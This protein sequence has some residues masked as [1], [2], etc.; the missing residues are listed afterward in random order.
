MMEKREKR[1]KIILFLFFVPF[2][3]WILFQ[4]LAPILLPSG[5]IS[6]LSGS[7][8]I[9]ENKQSI[10]SLNFPWNIIYQSGDALCHQ[11]SERSFFIN[12]NQMPYCARCT[13]IW[14]GITIGIGFMIFF[15]MEINEKFLISIL[16]GLIPIGIDGIGQLFGLW[17]SNNLVRLIT[18]LLA[19][20]ITGIAIGTIIDE[21]RDI[22]KSKKLKF[23]QKI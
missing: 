7:T 21:L 5:T 12:E 23:N 4:L 2:L 20:I 11:K 22:I 14:L 10:E 19:G 6:D 1:S 3:F 18:G 8:I 15:K 16:I 17:E 13:A 9:Q